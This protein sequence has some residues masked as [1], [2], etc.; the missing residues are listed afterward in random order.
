LL[1]YP[2]D[3]QK[4]EKALLFQEIENILLEN[5][6]H[7][8]QYLDNKLLHEIENAYSNN[9]EAIEKFK[10]QLQLTDDLIDQVVYRLYGLTQEEIDIVEGR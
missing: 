2:R 6:Q 9:L 3:Y 5:R 4:G 10:Q 8:R 7:F 1:N